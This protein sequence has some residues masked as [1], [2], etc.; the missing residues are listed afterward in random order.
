MSRIVWVSPLEIQ[1]EKP[2]M[3]STI[4]FFKDSIVIGLVTIVL[5]GIAEGVLRLTSPVAPPE[6][7]L[8]PENVAFQFHPDYLISLKPGVTKTFQRSSHNGGELIEWRTNEQSFRG[9]A[10]QARPEVRLMVYGDSNVQA[11]FSALENTFSHRLEDD[12]RTLTGRTVEVI[13]A[14]LAGSGPDQ[15]L[16]RMAHGVDEYDPDIVVFHIFADNDF[17]DLIRN[18]LFEL[19]S[20]GNLTKTVFPRELTPTD[21]EVL[22][23]TPWWKQLSSLR[24]L[25]AAYR[26]RELLQTSES[27]QTDVLSLL[28]T[29]V[30]K[31]FEVYREGK[32][33]A[34]SHFGDSYDLDVAARPDSESAR[35]KRALMAEILKAAQ[36]LLRSRGI[37]LVI[38]IQPSSRD[39]TENLPF[40]HVQLSAMPGYSPSNLS[41]AVEAICASL[42]LGCINLFDHFADNDPETL[43]FQ[44]DDDHWNDAGQALA[45][46]ITADYIAGS[47]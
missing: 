37:K 23:L 45:A 16:L 2:A 40:N 27:E 30:E 12:L 14:G 6:I 9:E 20:D 21:R 29:A 15:S 7:P 25:W 13:N 4:A 38:L 44:E 41:S 32:P 39:L 35:A 36:T 24:L 18:R 11:R 46:R 22:G 3:P 47:L 43:Y 42:N 1:F 33:R 19:D 8:P 17:G 10:L 26:I 28:E 34:Y 31:E 5:L